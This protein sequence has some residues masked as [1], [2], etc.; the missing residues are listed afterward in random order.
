MNDKNKLQPTSGNQLQ[1]EEVDL[2]NLFKVIGK[3]IKNFY[4]FLGDILQSIFHYFILFLI[5]IKNN[6]LKLGLALVLGFMVGLFLHYLNPKTY[7][8]EMIVETNYGSGMQLY[9]QIDYLNDLVKKKDSISL[10][11][12]LN[13]NVD[14]ASKISNFKV[15]P[16]QPSQNLYNAYDEYLIKTDTIFTRDYKFED[17]KKRVDKY[18]LRYHQIE[19]SSELSTIFTKLSTSLIYLVESDYYKNKRDIKLNEI[20]Q[21]LSVLNKNLIQVDSLRKTYK[22]VALKEAENNSSTSTIQIAKSDEEQD[23]NDIKLFETTNDLLN[24]ISW[25]NQDLVRKNNVVNIISDF[26]KVGVP[27]NNITHKKYFRLPLL[28]LSFMLAWILIRQ[29]NS[30]LSNYKSIK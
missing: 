18:D 15:S 5:F 17:F 25:T 6:L 13:I 27:D 28:F 12:V 30:Y 21:K 8:S 3:G 10:S 4:N 11:S 22:K 24:N 26:D 7:V 2:G 16:Y 19:V 20:N 9:K 23:E 1:E 29:L 14:D